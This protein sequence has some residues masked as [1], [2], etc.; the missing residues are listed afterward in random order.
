ML[1][2]CLE[3]GIFA[4]T[5]NRYG[6]D[7]RPHGELRFT[8]KSQVAGPQGKLLYRAYSQ[9][10]ELYITETDV[11]LARDKSMT[12]LNDLIEDRRP[13]YYKPLIR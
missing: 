2:R 13:A 11:D 1:S 3:N 10:E 9:R 4:V 6:A 7:K 5:A 12:P 8:G